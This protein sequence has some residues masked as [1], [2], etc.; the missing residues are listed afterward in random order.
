[1]KFNTMHAIHNRPFDQNL[2]NADNFSMVQTMQTRICEVQTM[3]TR[4]YLMKA[5]KFLP[6]MTYYACN[7][8]LLHVFIDLIMMLNML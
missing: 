6:V 2:E 1:M 7:N 3:R 8:A 5:N 4:P